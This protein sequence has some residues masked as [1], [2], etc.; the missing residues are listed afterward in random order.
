[1]RRRICGRRFACARR[2]GQGARASC[3]AQAGKTRACCVY[4]NGLHPLCRRMNRRFN[5]PIWDN[6]RLD[7]KCQCFKKMSVRRDLTGFN[8]WRPLCGWPGKSGC[9][10]EV[11]WLSRCRQGFKKRYRCNGRANAPQNPGIRKDLTGSDK[12]RPHC[13][14]PGKSGCVCE[15]E[16]L[17][18]LLASLNSLH[19]GLGK[20]PLSQTLQ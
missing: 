4:P 6:G 3:G 2:E 17:S 19:W 8:M 5:I 12:W 16:W 9:V 11:E 10:C 18:A 1:M 13:G 20:I 7:W 14:W 15:V